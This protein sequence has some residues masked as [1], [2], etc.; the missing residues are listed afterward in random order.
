L[1]VIVRRRSSSFVVR[2][3]SSSFVVSLVVIARRDGSCVVEV[4]AQSA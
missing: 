1:F 4:L 2:R 3:R